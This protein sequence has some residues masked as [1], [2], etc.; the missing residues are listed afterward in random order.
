MKKDK[1]KV[2]FWGGGVA[3]QHSIEVESMKQKLS[4]KI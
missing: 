3:K 2:F 4:N 1:I